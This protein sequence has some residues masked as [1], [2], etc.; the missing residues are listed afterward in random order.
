MG[1][2]FNAKNS[3]RRINSGGIIYNIQTYQFWLV[4]S[5]ISRGAFSYL[6]AIM[7]IFTF[8]CDCSKQVNQGIRRRPDLVQVSCMINCSK[9]VRQKLSC[10][11]FKGRIS[12]RILFIRWR[13]SS[14]VTCSAHE[15]INNLLCS[16]F[17]SYVMQLNYFR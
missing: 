5:S 4:K 17:F 15:I 7:I 13:I 14:L 10:R 8:E 12:S 16:V 9:H 2:I 1:W 11:F 6:T 3:Q